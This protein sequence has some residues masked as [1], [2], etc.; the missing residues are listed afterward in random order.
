MYFRRDGSSGIKAA[1]MNYVRFVVGRRHE[2]PWTLTGVIVTAK[3][4]MKAGKL[5]AEECE[6]VQRT[7]DWFNENVPCPPFQKCLKSKKWSE[8]AVAWFR[9]TARTPINKLNKLIK[10]LRNHGLMVRTMKSDRP[11]KIVYSDDF[12][13]VAETPHEHTT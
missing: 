13:V 8:D 1:K 2:N 4:L 9:S 3:D 6:I 5:T 11:G 12:Q 10:V 7:F